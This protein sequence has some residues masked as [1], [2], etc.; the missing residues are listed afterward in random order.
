MYAG[1]Q[2]ISPLSRAAV[3]DAAYPIHFLSVSRASARRLQDLRTLSYAGDKAKHVQATHSN[4]PI[5]TPSGIQANGSTRS[6]RP[7]TGN[8][9]LDLK[10]QHFYR[11]IA[12]HSKV[13]P[14]NQ[15]A[16]VGTLPSRRACKAAT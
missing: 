16:P 14:A 7:D 6:K 1:V 12:V 4:D 11:E 8:G 9:L 13:C 15:H 10:V 5:E 2:M 3:L